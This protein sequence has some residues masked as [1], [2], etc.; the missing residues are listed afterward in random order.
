[1]R[2]TGYSRLKFLVAGFL[3]TIAVSAQTTL[4]GTITDS[5]GSPVPYATVYIQELQMGTT[6]NAMGNYEIKLEDGTYT[7]FYQSL[8][9][10]QDFR[11]VAIAGKPVIRNVSLTVQYFQLPEVTVS[12]GREDPAY[13]IIRRAIARAP[14]YLNAVERYRA[15]VYLKGTAV[16]DRMPRLLSRAMQRDSDVD[17]KIGETYFYESHNEIE[18]NAPDKYV[19]RL[20]AIQS[21]FPSESD[22]ISPMSYIQA[23]FYEPV[24][25]DIAISPLAQNAMSHYRY[26]Y[27]G[28]S[29][30]GQ[31]VINKIRVIPR[32]KSQQVFSGVIY[33][34]EDLWC[35]HSLDLENESLVGKIRVRQIHTPVQDDFW[36]P[37]SHNFDVD[38]SMLG[39]RGRAT[40]GSAVKYSEIVTTAPLAI[41]TS[42]TVS[43]PVSE[44]VAAESPPSRTAM[45]MEKL[46]AKDDLTNREMIRLSRMM[47]KEAASSKGDEGKRELE[48]RQTTQYIIEEDA[49]KKSHDFWADIRPIPLADNEIR[50]LRLTDSLKTNTL[51]EVKTGPKEVSVSLSAGKSTPFTRTVRSVMAGKTWRLDSNRVSITY[52]GIAKLD[53]FSF[54][55]V[56]GLTYDIDFRFSRRWKNGTSFSAFPEIGYAFSR[57]SLFWTLNTTWNY[58]KNNNDYFWLRAGDRSTEFN[59]YGP[60]NRFINTAYSLL[61]KENLMRLYRSQYIRMGHRS[62]I[63]NG[64]YLEVSAGSEFRGLLDN[65][66]RFSF[67]RRDSLYK[68]NIPGNSMVDPE[69]HPAYVP[70]NH[71]HYFFNA[72]LTIIPFQRYRMSGGRKFPAGSD[73]PTFMVSYRQ[74]FNDIEGSISTFSRFMA[75]A[76]NRKDTG[77]MAEL[78]WKVRTGMTI[79][80]DS[81]TFHDFIHFNTQPIPLLLND[82]R[83]AFFLP[84]WY[85]LA[86]DRWFIE[87]HLRYTNPYIL[88]KLLPGLSN[89]LMRENLHA[90]YLLSPQMKH[91]F[92]FGYSISEIFLLGEAGVFAGF[93]NSGFRSAGVRFILKFN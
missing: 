45:E 70:F 14:Y 26:S 29:L 46:L 35:I 42:P 47:E 4:S 15:M 24:I 9:Y 55:S 48:I 61:L 57:E 73:Y 76:S 83:D 11:Q 37:V 10:N 50:S 34:V 23:S 25:A 71:T 66:T 12:T 5:S 1:M 74:G 32:R 41:V 68:P 77:P 58:R 30:Q 82:Y 31:Y 27:E 7:V 8:G 43:R 86:T 2:F 85:T 91:Y 6:A 36:M 51:K 64:L 63:S 22:Q 69:N 54:N 93:E 13:A 44:T 21:T 39:I 19:H 20:I 52:G 87:G 88:V 84:G 59:N 92:E 49:A 62:E 28:S 38:F 65:N 67:F 56:D 79:S 89:T 16:L 3:L 81:I 72:E 40:Y 60:A 78:F 33:I 17:I 75:S 90:R 80:A 53:N 18:F